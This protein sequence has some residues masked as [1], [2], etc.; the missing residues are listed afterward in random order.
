[1][2]S[3]YFTKES[4]PY[5][6]TPSYYPPTA[7][8]SIFGDMSNTDQISIKAQ[9]RNRLNSCRLA[10]MPAGFPFRHVHDGHGSYRLSYDSYEFREDFLT[11]S[12]DQRPRYESATISFSQPSSRSKTKYLTW[13]AYIPITDTYSRGSYGKSA[14]AHVQVD[15]AAL[16]TP[17]GQT[18]MTDP[19]V[20]LR[21]LAISLELGIVVTIQPWDGAAPT[22]GP[23]RRASKCGQSMRHMQATLRPGSIVY[24]ATSS[25][26]TQKTLFYVN[27]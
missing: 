24:L 3:F 22:N 1:M 4:S 8:K 12:H 23:T 10:N 26:G 7:G 16:K 11:S 17:Y 19:L 21:A 20:V 13:R 25:D 14:I 15:P 27:H 18:L 9:L 2:S 5:L 6:P